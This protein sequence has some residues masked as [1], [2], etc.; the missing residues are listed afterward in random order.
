MKNSDIGLSL[1]LGALFFAVIGAFCDVLSAKESAAFLVV[2][3]V[4]G[5]LPQMKKL[6]N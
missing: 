3:A 4:L 5:V 6:T 2:V 1:I